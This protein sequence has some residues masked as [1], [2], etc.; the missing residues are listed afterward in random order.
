MTAD[1]SPRQ[2]GTAVL[3]ALVLGLSVLGFLYGTSSSNYDLVA[4]LTVQPASQSTT[5][6]APSYAQERDHVGL[7]DDDIARACTDCHKERIATSSPA[8]QRHE[9][10]VGVKP[11]P[12]A[13]LQDLIDVG[14]QIRPDANGDLII[15]CR[16]CHRPHN[17]K[18]DAR[19][20][21]SVDDGAL[22]LSCHIDKHSRSSKH[23]VSG[24]IRAAAA[25]RIEAAGGLVRDGGMTCLSCHDPH[26]SGSAPLLRAPGGKLA[27]CKVCHANKFHVVDGPHS[28]RTCIDCH[29][30][31]DAPTLPKAATVANVGPQLCLDC[32]TTDAT[33]HRIDVKASHPLGNT[34]TTTHEGLPLRDGRIAC[35]TC[36]DPHSSGSELIRAVPSVLC[37]RCHQDQAS[38]LGTDHD[39]V[40]GTFGDDNDGTCLT[41]HDVHG[42]TADYLVKTRGKNENPA[43]G[44]C[45]RCHD[46]STSATQ[47]TYT[48]HPKGL[49]LTSAGLPFQYGGETPYFN[50]SGRRTTNRKVGEITCSTCHDPHK[51][52]HDSDEA[53]GAVQGSE[54]NSFLRDPDQ[55]IQFCTVCH[56]VDARPRFRFFHT[57]RFRDKDKE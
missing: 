27:T 53:P 56:G 34:V 25:A 7:S 20:V 22:C 40:S 12:G 57:D 54:Q 3:F 14:G 51:W 37:T 10:P 4:P 30:M 24:Q 5:P 47:V 15:G 9:H 28:A 41:C 52:K 6:V 23:P 13:H 35:T 36:H 46:G 2:R 38:V 33:K 11:P 18:Q 45:L 8:G 44:R 48:T 55:T 26:D 29:G 49:L 32:H 31:H 39:A 50:A 43:I 42:S 1:P 19:L 21:V 17:V 16:T